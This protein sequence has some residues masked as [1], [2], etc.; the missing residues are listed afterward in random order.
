MRPIANYPGY[1]ISVDG[2]VYSTVRKKGVFRRKYTLCRDGYKRLRLKKG[3]E[4]IRLHREVL[5]T[6][7]RLPKEGEIC[8]HLDGNPSN[9]N[10]WNLKWGTPKE[11]SQD[12]LKHGRNPYQRRGEKS[13]RAKFSD[14]EVEEIRTWHRAGATYKEITTMYGISKAHVSDLINEKSRPENDNKD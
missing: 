12:C 13:V 8:R 9:N 3:G 10:I 1:Y 5:K 6:F 2:E 11:N 7:D 4:T 14:Q